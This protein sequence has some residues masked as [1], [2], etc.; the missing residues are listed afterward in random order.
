MAQFGFYTNE[1]LH[2]HELICDVIGDQ[3]ECRGLFVHII[4]LNFWALHN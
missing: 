2:V 1:M 3:M 4:G